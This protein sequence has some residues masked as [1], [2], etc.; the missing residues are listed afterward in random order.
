MG[1]TWLDRQASRLRNVASRANVDAVKGSYT[2]IS[3]EVDG[4]K[5][6]ADVSTTIVEAI[7]AVLA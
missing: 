4:T 3:V 2:D 5:S 1:R 7:D 6:P